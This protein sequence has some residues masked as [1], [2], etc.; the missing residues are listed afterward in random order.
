MCEYRTLHLDSKIGYVIQCVHCKRITIGFGIMTVSRTVEEFHK[1]LTDVHSCHE[2]HSLI[3][4]DPKVR[5]IPFWQMSEATCM[6]VSLNDLQQ[7][8]E[9]LDFAHARLQLEKMISSLPKN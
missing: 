9:L 4:R 2:Y 3:V 6:T 1:L 7:L 5:T 8:G